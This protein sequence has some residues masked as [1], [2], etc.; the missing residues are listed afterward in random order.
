MLVRLK[1]VATTLPIGS[2]KQNLRQ[3]GGLRRS[4]RLSQ[5]ERITGDVTRH[6]MTTALKISTFSQGIDCSMKIL[7]TKMQIALFKNGTKGM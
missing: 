7:S 1:E 5:A 2:N 3:N 6:I 4:H